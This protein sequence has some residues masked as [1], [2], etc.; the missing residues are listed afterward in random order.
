MATLVLLTRS[1]PTALAF[2]LGAFALVAIGRETGIAVRARHGADG[3]GWGRATARVL[4]GNPRRYG[5][6]TVHVGVVLIAVAIA[7]SHTFGS[8]A[9]VRLRRGESRE[10]AGHTFTY[11]G[12]RTSS[13]GQRT[14]VAADVRIER[15]RAVLGVYAPAVST[16][17]NSNQAIGTP[18][19]HTGPLRDVYLTL[20]SSPNRRGRITLGVGVNPMVVWIWIGGG[21]IALGTLAA[22][23]PAARRRV[24]PVATDEPVGSRS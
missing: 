23:A 10:V 21:L 6:L 15:G 11:L 4:A 19:V 24:R 14:T 18:S 7:A 13:T 12:S 20:V 2:G 8:R 17:P 3:C 16:F 5:G 9:E 1:V 22:L